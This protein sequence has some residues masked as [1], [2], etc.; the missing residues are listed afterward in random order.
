MQ[1]IENKNPSKA[2]DFLNISELK[3]MDW[4]RKQK[5]WQSWP[6]AQSLPIGE[7]FWLLGCFGESFLW[8]FIGRIKNK[9]G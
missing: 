9:V 6:A 5:H 7:V 8:V 4:Q 3:L 1:N 2:M